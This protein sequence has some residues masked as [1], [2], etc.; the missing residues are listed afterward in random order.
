[1]TKKWLYLA[2]VLSIPSAY[3]EQ[4]IPSQTLLQLH[5]SAIVLDSHLDTPPISRVRAGASS[6]TIKTIGIFPGLICRE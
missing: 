3:A 5:E 2:L 1:M 4:A 6:T